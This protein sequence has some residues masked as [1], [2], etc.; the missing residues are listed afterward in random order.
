M[1][2]IFSLSVIGL[3]L[4]L[5]GCATTPRPHNVE[6][7]CSIFKQYPSWRTHTKHAEK[8]WGTPVPVQMAIIY[9]ESSFSAKARPPRKKLLWIIPWKRPSSAYGYSQALNGT[10]KDY[11]RN[12]G[13]SGKRSAFDDATDFIGWYSDYVHR[14][15]GISP[16][17]PYRLYLVY[18]EGPGGYAHQSYLKKAWLM[19]TAHKV[20]ARAE[21]YRRQLETCGG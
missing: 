20:S 3:F 8:K 9:Q 12:V 18:H 4:F 11:E 7:V 13:G 6:N 2:K 5:A 14:K 15:L 16:S 10:W 17:D 19:R 21:T 1:K